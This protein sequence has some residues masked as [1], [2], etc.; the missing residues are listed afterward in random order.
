MS[1]R[2]NLRFRYAL[3]SCAWLSRKAGY[4]IVTGAVLEAG[5]NDMGLRGRPRLYANDAQR[6][7]AWRDR[8][9]LRRQEEE[10]VRREAE[11]ERWRRAEYER[12]QEALLV[13]MAGEYSRR[14]YPGELP[15]GYTHMTEALDIIECALDDPGLFEQVLRQVRAARGATVEA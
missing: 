2:G 15:N 5:G 7:A 6:Q 13:T 1:R 9:R 3:R 10:R 11:R 12:N 14:R 8:D 4:N